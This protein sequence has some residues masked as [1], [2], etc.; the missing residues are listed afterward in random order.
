MELS[1]LGFGVMRLPQNSDGSFPAST[2]ALLHRAYECGIN[3][4]DTG[5]EY[6]GGKSESLIRDTLVMNYP[7][8]S[9][10]IADKLP[11]WRISSHDDMERIFA[12]QLERLGTQYIDY[13]LLHAMNASYWEIMQKLDV[14]EFLDKKKQ[15]GQI[16][17]IGFSIHDNEITLENMLSAYGWDF[18]QLQINYY[19]WYAQHARENYRLCEER[20]IPVMVM[21]PIGGGRLLRLPPDAKAIVQ[22]AALTPSQLALRFLMGLS[23]VAVTLIGATTEEQ[24]NADIATVSNIF[25]ATSN[26]DDS[27]FENIVKT[28]QSKSTIPCTACKYCVKECPQKVDIPL[29]FQ[30][31]NDYKLL[32]LPDQYTNLGEFYFNCVPIECQASNCIACGNCVK[33]CPQHIDI[34]YELEKV[35][36]AASTELIGISPNDLSK[37]IAKNAVI[38]CF[39]AGGMGKSFI[40]ILSS[41]G[42]NVDYLCDN[43]SEMWGKK[44]DNIEIISPKRL[45]EMKDQA[46]VFISSQHYDDIYKQL[47]EIGISVCN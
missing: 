19:D 41:F 12:T 46:V 44:V 14:L 16:Q 29:C 8:N 10:C 9:F 28:I 13:Y 42:Y 38:V 40:N 43:S 2:I 37:K 4:F 34:P 1:P 33:R 36:I 35:H 47:T 23:D 27:I 24:L 25:D 39:G 5:Y 3:Y 31:Y 30:K 18:C 15:S 45:A 7:R 26:C 21:E 17:K 11:V 20:G 32:G 22:N 6:L